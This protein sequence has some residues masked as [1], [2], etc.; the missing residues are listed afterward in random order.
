[1][2]ARLG[3]PSAN[4]RGRTVALVVGIVA[5]IGLADYLAG[6]RV[7]LA[8]FY[9]IP[10][11]ISVAGLGWEAGCVTAVASIGVR[12]IGDQLAGGYAHPLVV[13]WNRS[14]DLFMY[15]VMV[16]IL[17]ALVSLWREVEERVGKRTASLQQIIAERTQL[18]NELFEISRRE[19]SA[20]GHDLH[21]GLGQELTA[22]SMAANLLAVDLA[23]ENHAAAN[24]ARTIVNMVQA[25]I[26][27]TRKIARGLLLSTVEPD[28]L[29]TELDELAAA[30][31]RDYSIACR[32][33]HRGVAKDRLDVAVAS[34]L[35]YIAQEAARNAARH[36]HASAVDISLFVDECALDLAVIDNGRGLPPA[37]ARPAGMGL[38]IMAHRAGLVG[39]EVSLGPGPAGGTAMRCHIPLRSPQPSASAR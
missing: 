38:R 18:Q 10:I 27:T 34:H 32:L 28:E 33:V 16:W 31:T 37:D 14:I 36:A 7:S 20:I 25:A 30:L 35:F 5:V 2:L 22:T 6:V 8:L 13:F 19:R 17:H 24:N 15:L 21:D 12:V 4:R 39:G 29:L 1:L 9:L 11:S 26:G 23:S 3:G